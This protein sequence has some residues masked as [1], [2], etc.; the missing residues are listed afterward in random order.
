MSN[1]SDRIANALA[2]SE[3]LHHA[4]ADR[5]G[6]HIRFIR[7]HAGDLQ[8]TALIVVSSDSAFLTELLYNRRYSPCRYREHAG[9]T[10]GAMTG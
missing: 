7:E 9:V 5:A 6:D 2:E 3:A 4:A 10:H 1:Q 8:P